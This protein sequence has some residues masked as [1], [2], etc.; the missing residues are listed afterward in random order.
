[1]STL[2]VTVV[3]E[4][5]DVEP[6]TDDSPVAVVGVTVGTAAGLAWLAV[7]AM[8]WPEPV[9]GL[10]APQ[11]G[12]AA[13]VAATSSGEADLMVALGLNACRQRMRAA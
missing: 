7:A 9:Q 8:L 1:M 13:L 12:V 10:L 3:F 5:H 2:R 6:G 4:F 11:L